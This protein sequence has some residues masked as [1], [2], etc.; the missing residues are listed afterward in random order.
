MSFNVDVSTGCFPDIKQGDVIVCS[1]SRI[2]AAETAW[3]VVDRAPMN[4]DGLIQTWWVTRYTPAAEQFYNA[5]ITIRDGSNVD[6]NGDPLFNR[7]VTVDCWID[8]ASSLLDRV[9][10]EHADDTIIA[11]LEREFLTSDLVWL[12]DDEVNLSPKFGRKFR[13]VWS[14]RRGGHRVYLGEL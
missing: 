7:A 6:T 3:C 13:R 8:S 4:D 14:E 10:Y 2:V 9:G 5:T 11:T 12:P 1:D